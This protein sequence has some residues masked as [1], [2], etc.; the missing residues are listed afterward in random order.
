MSYAPEVLLSKKRALVRFASPSMFSV[1][2]KLV[3][4]VLTAL[5]W[6]ALGEAGQAR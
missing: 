2:M 3:L 1:P 6:Y 4:S 5:I